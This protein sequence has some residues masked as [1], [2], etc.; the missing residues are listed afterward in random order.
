MAHRIFLTVQAG[1]TE[2][3][4][5]TL[6]PGIV[7]GILDFDGLAVNPLKEMSTWSAR[8]LQNWRENH[9]NCGRCGHNCPC[10]NSS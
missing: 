1:C 2:V 8:L 6:P 4:E 9:K 3:C 5:D 7:V 10:R